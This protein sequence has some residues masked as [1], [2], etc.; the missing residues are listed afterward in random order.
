MYS[1]FFSRIKGLRESR[2]DPYITLSSPGGTGVLLRHLQGFWEIPVL[3]R[4]YCQLHVAKH[5]VG[6][7]SRN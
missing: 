6:R 4:F 1:A 7:G 3:V 2:M 5:P